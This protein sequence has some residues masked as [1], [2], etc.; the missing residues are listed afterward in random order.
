MTGDRDR[1]APTSDR[2][3]KDIDAGRSGDKVGFPDPAAAPLGTDDEAA[4][5][6]PDEEQLRRAAEAETGRPA[7]APSASVRRRPMAGGDGTAR[8][9]RRPGLRIA[10]M[11]V[12][13]LIAV[14]LVWLAS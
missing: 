9:G 2:L 12:L 14:A 8:H 3:R 4:G 13:G 10:A 7:V 6:P 11:A 5:T 1:R